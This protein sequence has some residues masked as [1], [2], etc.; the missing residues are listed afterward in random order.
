MQ[1]Q[2]PVLSHSY[3]AV[4][5]CFKGGICVIN[6]PRIIYGEILTFTFVSMYC[7]VPTDRKSLLRSGLQKRGILICLF[8]RSLAYRHPIKWAESLPQLH[9]TAKE[10]IQ[11]F[12]K[13]ILYILSFL[14]SFR[15]QRCFLTYIFIQGRNN[16]TQHHQVRSTRNWTSLSVK[17]A[18]SYSES[19]GLG[20]DITD[21]GL[22]TFAAR[23]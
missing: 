3:I 11:F 23:Y 6:L 7:N 13:P 9:N 5:F 1:K 10:L 19:S 22:H 20:K 2:N 17:A 14:F 8:K 15:G 4:L 12:S 16:W 21:A 18:V